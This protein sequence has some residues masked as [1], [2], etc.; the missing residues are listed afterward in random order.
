MEALLIVHLSP[1][2][3][4]KIITATA[5]I[6]DAGG[7]LEGVRQALTEAI[8]GLHCV[9]CAVCVCLCCCRHAALLTGSVWVCT[10]THWCPSQTS[11]CV[12]VWLYG[13]GGGGGG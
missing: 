12:P 13:G 5:L 4:M 2:V 9:Q 6:S 3:L 10:S 11:R 1:C 7:W 8:E